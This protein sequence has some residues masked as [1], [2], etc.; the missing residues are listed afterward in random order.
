MTTTW[1]RMRTLVLAATALLFMASAP[2]LGQEEQQEDGQQ[3]GQNEQQ[4]EATSERAG[5]R[6]AHL[7][8]GGSSVDV[9]VDGEVA[10]EGLSPN[11]A[12]GYL[13]FP[14]GEHTV[15]VVS[16]GGGGGQ[17]QQQQQDPQQQEP[18]GDAAAQDP[19]AGDQGMQDPAMGDEA[20]PEQA[21][22]ASPEGPLASETVT[23]EAGTY[24]T[25]LLSSAGGQQDEQQQQADQDGAMDVEAQLLTDEYDSL[26]GAGLASVRVVGGAPDVGSVTVVV[27]PA[28]GEQEQ[29][30]NG[31]NQE[32]QQE[33]QEQD[34]QQDEQQD[35]EEQNQQEEE[36]QEG[37]EPIQ[38]QE[39]AS[40][41]AFGDGG[42]YT[43]VTAGQHRVQVQ[44][45]DGTVIADV[46]QMT[47][48]GGLMY[49]LYVASTGEGEG[50]ALL[51]PAVDGG[52]SRYQP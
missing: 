31:E 46:R 34:E 27:G 19:A 5:L 25:L 18:A 14:S 39:V 51:T 49:T 21:Q 12:T 42:P 40:G 4:Q 48:E 26:P 33:E 45:E 35:V 24:G 38:G 8:G 23:L 29:Q 17:Q 28:D 11:R 9:L 37:P 15:E 30:Q 47:L 1:Q 50:S 13:H 20:A 43:T 10:I 41:L 52:V 16:A 44:S 32:Q 36:Q 3:D 22:P 6:V 2:A 7:V